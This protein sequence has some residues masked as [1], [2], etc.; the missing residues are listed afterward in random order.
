MASLWVPEKMCRPVFQHDAG[1]AEVFHGGPLWLTKSTVRPARATSPIFPDALL[2]EGRVAHREHFVHDQDLRLQV[3]GDGEGQP[4]VHAAGVA[5]HRRVDEL[6]R[7]S[8][9]ATISSNLRVD[10]ALA[11]AEDGAVE[12]DVLAA[13]ELRVEAGADLQQ[14]GDLA[15][16]RAR[17]P[18]VGAVIRERIFRRVDLPEPLRPM[19]PSTSPSFTSKID[20][21]ERPEVGVLLMLRVHLRVRIGLSAPARPA[22][23]EVFVEHPPVDDAEAVALGEIFDADDGGHEEL[24]LF[25]FLVIILEMRK[26][27]G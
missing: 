13:G 8:E 23:L 15:L 19:T 18:S 17:G 26:T 24:I 4:H 12:I 11:H 14:T 22:A 25:L 20:V 2:L 9:K 21:L 16:D 1:G 5:L 10:L 27:R 6:P 7:R 3:R